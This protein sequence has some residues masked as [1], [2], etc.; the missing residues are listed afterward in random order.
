MNRWYLLA[1]VVFLAMIAWAATDSLVVLTGIAT[2]LDTL[3]H[4]AN[5]WAVL[6]RAA[7][8]EQP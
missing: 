4:N 5:A 8:K 2:S 6:S 1:I 3:R 7:A